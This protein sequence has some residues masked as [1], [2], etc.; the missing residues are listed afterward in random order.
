MVWM[1]TAHCAR[2]SLLKTHHLT[3][4]PILFHGCRICRCELLTDQRP[5]TEWVFAIRTGLVNLMQQHQSRNMPGIISSMHVSVWNYFQTYMSV[6]GII[7][8]PDIHGSV[9]KYF[10]TYKS[11]SG[12]ISRHISQ[13]QVL[14]PDIRGS[15]VWKYFQTNMSVPG[16]ISRHKTV[17]GNISRQICLE[18]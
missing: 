13:C 12:I 4:Q 18:I 6:S 16:T 15:S 9:W 7:F 11:V 17:S 14:F 8:F 1:W 10:Q 2:C 5:L 3:A